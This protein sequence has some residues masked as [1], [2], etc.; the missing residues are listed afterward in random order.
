MTI[1]AATG[2]RP[3]KLGGYDPKLSVMRTEFAMDWLDIRQIDRGITGMALGWDQD[4]ALACYELGIPY[5]AAVP[6]D[7][8]ESRWPDKSK[9]VYRWLMNRAAEI[10]VV[11]PGGYS[12]G[13][14][15]LRNEWMVAECNELLA[16]YDGSTG[17]TYHC[18]KYAREWGREVHNL[19]PYYAEK[20]RL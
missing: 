15:L 11:S 20:A 13:K 8:Q 18:V 3:D 14:M 12:A 17:G 19:Y 9:R 2:H 6:F 5:T 10:I 16:M 7:G 1:V 4:F